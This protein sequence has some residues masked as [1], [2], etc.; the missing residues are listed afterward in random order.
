MSD[1]HR[2]AVR[3]QLAP[4]TL[5]VTDEMDANAEGAPVVQAIVQNARDRAARLEAVLR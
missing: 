5:E 1:V 2:A 3:D 4:R